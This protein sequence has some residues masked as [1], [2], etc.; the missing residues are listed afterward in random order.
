[1][2]IETFT[3]QYGIVLLL[4][5]EIN[6]AALRINRNLNS[7]NAIDFQDRHTPHVTLY[8]ASFD[9]AQID[10]VPM[11]LQEIKRV[12]PKHLMHFF[13]VK[14]YAEKFVFWH[15]ADKKAYME[16]HLLA[17]ILAPLRSIP[18]QTQVQKE[19]LTLSPAEQKNVELFGHPLVNELWQP[20][21]TVGY[22]PDGAGDINESHS[23]IGKVEAVA[24][25]EVGDYGTIKR[26]VCQL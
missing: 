3:G 5:S 23:Q 20:H 13:Q 1:M 17:M 6:R 18:K 2:S 4:D 14:T 11:F 19:N 15:L 8:H 7:G 12:L 24:F 10:D 25:V 21:V 16:A 26:I 22:Y 9:N